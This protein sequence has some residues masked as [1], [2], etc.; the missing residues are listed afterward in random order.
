[1]KYKV[2][3]LGALL[4]GLIFVFG[5]A[6]TGDL[7]KAEFNF[8]LKKYDEAIPFYE[9]Y[10]AKQPNSVE[11]R[12]RLGFSY[13]KTGWL[14]EAISEFQTVL[15][16][17]PS[18]SS[19]TYYLGLAYLNK[20][21]FKN[22]IQT[23]QGYRNE[24][25][26][27]VEEEIRRQ[28]TLLQI[29]NSH[30]KAIEALSEEKQLLAAKPDSNTVAICYYQDLSP[31][32]SLDAL[33]KGIAAM[34]ISCLK[35][36]RSLKVVERVRVQA[37][38][39]EMKLGKANPVD[40]KVAMKVG[41]LLGAEN[42]ILGNISAGSIKATTTIVSSLTD[43][44][45]SKSSVSVDKDKFFELPTLITLDIAKQIGIRLTED[46]SRAIGIPHTKIYE[47]AVYFGM[48]VEALDAEKWKDAKKFFGLAL[49]KDPAFSLARQ[50]SDFCPGENFSS[51]SPVSSMSIS[52]FSDISESAVNAAIA[53][54]AES[55]AAAS[56]G[57]GDG[58]GGG[59]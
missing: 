50:M 42:V 38:L 45:R 3:A 59:G 7:I 30:R 4:T 36:V 15:E 26:P 18:E 12:S 51:V 31:D 43:S 46:E 57:G 27:I 39:D 58:G 53:S 44:V 20:G 49:K 47:A 11:A 6:G 25:Q 56:T 13:Y 22:A 17:E 1:M 40:L 21:D 24:S 52:R 34:V 28:L 54:Q 8:D 33:Q 41:K 5:C 29:A 32:R 16:I 2:V 37:L 48:A 19:S 23:W 35:K 9:G 55:D 10:L 14:D